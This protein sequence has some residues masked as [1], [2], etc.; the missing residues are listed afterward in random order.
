MREKKKNE[1]EDGFFFRKGG[2]KDE[3]EEM[4]GDRREREKLRSW[5]LM[6]SYGNG[7]ATVRA[8]FEIDFPR[9]FQVEPPLKVGLL[10]A[11]EQ[12]TAVERLGPI[13]IGLSTTVFC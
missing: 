9:W 7:G 6:K 1:D 8:R 12:G 10:T 13:G 2:V 5:E 4:N 3:D 11:V